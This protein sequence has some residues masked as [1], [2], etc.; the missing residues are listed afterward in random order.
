M[1]R[2]IEYTLSD[3]MHTHTYTECVRD[4]EID[5]FG[6]IYVFF[7]HLIWAPQQP[8]FGIRP[9]GATLAFRTPRPRFGADVAVIVFLDGV[10]AAVVVKFL[11]DE[12]ALAGVGSL[13]L[14]V[15][16]WLVLL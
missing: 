6:W 2:N 15:V 11:F 14:T 9:P 1:M 13:T 5:W 3:H 10:A 8:H 7:V 4:R 12:P 16:F